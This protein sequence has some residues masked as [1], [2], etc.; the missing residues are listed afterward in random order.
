[1]IINLTRKAALAMEVE[2]ARSFFSKALGLMFRSGLPDGRGML[3]PFSGEGRVGIWMLFMRFPIDLVYVNSA[4]RVVGIFERVRPVNWRPGTWKVY[5]PP[6]PA[7]YVLEVASGTV[8]RTG[9]EIGDV[10][11]FQ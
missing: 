2:T 4:K 11:E 5:Y 8:K 6:V 10:L 9:T 7:R 3:F 1:M